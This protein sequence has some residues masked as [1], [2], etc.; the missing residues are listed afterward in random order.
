MHGLRSMEPG[1]RFGDPLQQTVHDLANGSP[2]ANHTEAVVAIRK[3]CFGDWPARALNIL[4]PAQPPPLRFYQTPDPPVPGSRVA[5]AFRL[6][7]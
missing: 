5:A 2:P 7:H 1:R 6:A 4:S 3:L